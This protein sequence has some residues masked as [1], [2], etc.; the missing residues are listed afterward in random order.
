VADE[1]VGGIFKAGA[2]RFD[3]GMS[4]GIPYILSVGA[5][6]M[7]NFGAKETV[8]E[9]CRG[10]NL[11]VHNSQITLMRTSP[12]E[13]RQCARW[14]AK[15]INKSTG[16]LLLLLPEQGLSALDAPGQPFHDPEADEA[17]F[18]ELE[19]TIEQTPAR[20]IRRL[21]FHINDAEFSEALVK[22]FLEI[23]KDLG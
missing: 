20:Q 21:P 23:T 14:I 9:K 13:N 4:K 19:S 18:S 5:M 8:P 7:V 17:L 22:G 1:I 10:R 15:K 3:V 11:L 6:D 12:E 2:A 16:P